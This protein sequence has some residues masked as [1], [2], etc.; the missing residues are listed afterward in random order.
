MQTEKNGAYLPGKIYE[1]APD[2]TLK[3]KQRWIRLLVR[4][5]PSADDAEAERLFDQLGEVL[6]NSRYGEYF[7]LSVY[8]I[9]REEEPE[10]GDLPRIVSQPPVVGIKKIAQYLGTEIKDLEDA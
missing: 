1:G 7:V 3:N 8:R 10:Y 6:R 4:E 5:R 9:N 2:F